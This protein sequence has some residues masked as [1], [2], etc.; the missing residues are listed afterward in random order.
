VRGRARWFVLAAV[1][2]AV[3]ALAL[4]VGLPDPVTL[5]ERA[6]ALGPWGPLVFLLVHAL[7]TTTP[8]PRTTFTISA[9]LLF[10]PWVGVGVCLAASTVSAVLGFL[11]SRRLG[12]RAV[13]R[14]GEGRVRAVERR[15][16]RRGLVTVV[17]SRLV[18]ALPFALLNYSFG[19][20]TVRM[21]PYLVGTAVGLVPGTVAVVLAGDAV[22]GEASPTTLAVFVVSGL[23]GVAGVLWSAR[24][25]PGER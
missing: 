11:L 17:S 18:P 23:L 15:L 3:A 1:L 2:V 25:L 6:R 16:S 14:L 9:G 8:F 7:V 12:G 13:A 5:R 21:S 24:R 4:T 19:V 10:G 22:T 20:T